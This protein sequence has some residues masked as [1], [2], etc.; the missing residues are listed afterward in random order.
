ML[1]ANLLWI[2]VTMY[3]HDSNYFIR[4]FV[5]ITLEGH[6]F[7]LQQTID[8]INISYFIICFSKINLHP[9]F[10]LHIKA[11]L[12]YRKIALF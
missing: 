5:E 9:L 10:S 3:V 12:S 4:Y 1:N 11:Y 6:V 7:S 8:N 2:S